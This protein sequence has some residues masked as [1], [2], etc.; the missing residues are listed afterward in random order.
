ML[1]IYILL[2]ILAV[3]MV[4]YALPASD[5]IGGLAGVFADAF[6]TSNWKLVIAVGI[7]LA[8]ALLRSFVPKLDNGKIAFGLALALGAASSVA[9][10]LEA[11]QV[12]TGVA[13]VKAIFD[14]AMTA[15]VAS[16][17]WSGLKKLSDPKEK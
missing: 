10:G 7:M 2:M 6:Q 1:G 5:D 3:P 12:T 4:A 8:V 14:G 15:L 16:G 13:I 11:G 9:T 17:L